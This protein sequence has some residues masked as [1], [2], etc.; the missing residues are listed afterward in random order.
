MC[1]AATLTFATNLPA[2]TLSRNLFLSFFRFI[3]FNDLKLI[4]L[5]QRRRRISAIGGVIWPK[6]ALRH[7]PIHVASRCL[8]VASQCSHSLRLSPSVLRLLWRINFSAITLPRQRV[9]EARCELRAVLEPATV[10]FYELLI[11][12][13]INFRP[14]LPAQLPLPKSR[15]GAVIKFNFVAYF[16]GRN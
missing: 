13:L 9:I 6:R 3:S 16:R 2:P 7:T 1:A 4:L 12:F 11:E 10:V 5:W 8:I 15:N 14:P